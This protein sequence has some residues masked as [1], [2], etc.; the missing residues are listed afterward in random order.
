MTT[1]L[2]GY[3]GGRW[4]SRKGWVVAHLIRP[5]TDRRTQYVRTWCGR[6]I[7]LDDVVSAAR[8]DQCQWCLP[9]EVRV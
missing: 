7:P 2:V 1:T 3:D 4:A 8:A 9:R 6:A 5:R